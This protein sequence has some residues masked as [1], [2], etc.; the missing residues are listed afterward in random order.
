VLALVVAVALGWLTGTV[1]NLMDCYFELGTVNGA[2]G[3]KVND[4]LVL[5][6]PLLAIQSNNN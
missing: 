3:G 1:H 5:H 6:M 4:S 2:N